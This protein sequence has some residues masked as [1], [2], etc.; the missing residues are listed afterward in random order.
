[1]LGSLGFPE[2]FLIFVIALLLFGPRRMPKMIRTIGRTV[3]E[4]KRASNDF[5]RTIEQ[6]IVD[7]DLRETGRELRSAIAE[8]RSILNGDGLTERP[9]GAQPTRHADPG[10]AA[11]DPDSAGQTATNQAATN[12]AATNQTVT[13]QA[14]TNQAAPDQESTP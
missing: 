13:N 8:G 6:E 14:V 10:P 2:I 5:K 3:G 1:M 12:Q 11:T 4:I 9:P 7:E